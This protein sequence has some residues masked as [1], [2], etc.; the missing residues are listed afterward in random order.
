MANQTN[1]STQ[2][3]S[4]AI[5]A[6]AYTQ[7]VSVFCDLDIDILNANAAVVNS[8]KI[9]FDRSVSLETAMFL[10]ENF[11][12]LIGALVL[13]YHNCRSIV[14]DAIDKELEIDELPADAKKAVRSEL[15]KGAMMPRTHCMELGTTIFTNDTLAVLYQHVAMG[16]NENSDKLFAKKVNERKI[17]DSDKE[18]LS[19]ILSNYVYLL[20]AFNH[21]AKFLAAMITIAEEIKNE[22]A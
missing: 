21:N 5:M 12:A 8:D 13:D 3:M 14:A 15:N 17:T 22:T 4:P 16:F 7:S 6:M 9:D 2:V 19:M 20:R 18:I 11:A 10:A 1:E